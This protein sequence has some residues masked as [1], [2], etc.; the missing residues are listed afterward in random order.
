M[1]LI[2][3]GANIWDVNPDG[4]APLEIASQ[5]RTQI[6]T[7][8]RKAQRLEISTG[9]WKAYNLAQSPSTSSSLF[10]FPSNLFSQIVKFACDG[11]VETEL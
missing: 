10:C 9:C 1:S 6:L 4:K 3:A 2:Q 11:S 5:Q 7:L 8:L